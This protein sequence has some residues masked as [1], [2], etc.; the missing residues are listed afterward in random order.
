MKNNTKNK[1][2]KQVR[3]YMQQRYAKIINYLYT[4]KSDDTE[5]TVRFLLNNE[6]EF[7]LEVQQIKEAQQ[8]AEKKKEFNSIDMSTTE[9]EKYLE[10]IQNDI[11]LI[12]DN[13][14]RETNR[15]T[16]TEMAL[17]QKMGHI[18]NLSEKLE[19][20]ESMYNLLT[21]MLSTTKK[22]KSIKAESIKDTKELTDSPALKVS[23]NNMC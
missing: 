15:E 18:S 20:L 2:A 13:L 6:P 19:Q 9:L 12:M 3:K 5:S 22:S 4:N 21:T 7:L 1:L 8:L 23:E 14:N 17:K 16:A 11:L 10:N